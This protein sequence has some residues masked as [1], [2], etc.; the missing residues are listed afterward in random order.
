MNG[1]QQGASRRAAGRALQHPRASAPN[2][3]RPHLLEGHAQRLL[4]FLHRVLK[5]IHAANVEE[6][7]VH[8]ATWA[9]QGA[10]ARARTIGSQLLAAAGAARLANHQLAAGLGGRGAAQ[11]APPRRR[12]PHVHLAGAGR[13]CGLL[14]ECS[15][16]TT[17]TLPHSQHTN[18]HATTRE[19]PCLRPAP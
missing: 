16:G 3:A 1:G 12:G 2:L 11:G 14:G 18:T 4:R 5:R 13:G 15:G 9:A 8:A 6:K 10:A 19:L 17:M 7:L